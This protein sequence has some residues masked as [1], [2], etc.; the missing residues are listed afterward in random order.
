MIN[1]QHK[2]PLER[3]ERG[4]IWATEG[5]HPTASCGSHYHPS[6]FVGMRDEEEANT[7]LVTAAYNAF[8]KTARDLGVAAVELA[9]KF[10]LKEAIVAW[11]AC[12]GCEKKKGVREFLHGWFGI[13]KHL[14]K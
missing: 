10:P 2:G 6:H 3:D 11:A 12:Y 14:K 4:H 1:Q 5:S 8:D 9:E 13:T 7:N